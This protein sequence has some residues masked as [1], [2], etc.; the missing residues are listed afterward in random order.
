MQNAN[1]RQVTQASRKAPKLIS[2]A[3]SLHFL[4]A[5]RLQNPF[6]VIVGSWIE[7][8]MSLRAIEVKLS[9]SLNSSTLR[10][11]FFV[12]ASEKGR[13]P[14]GS[15]SGRQRH[16]VYAHLN[17]GAAGQGKVNG[18]REGLRKGKGREADTYPCNCTLQV[19]EWRVETA[20][21]WHH[22]AEVLE[23]RWSQLQSFV[24]LISF[25]ALSVRRIFVRW[26]LP[27]FKTSSYHQRRVNMGELKQAQERMILLIYH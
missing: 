13:L 3:F 22:Q 6:S 18:Q 21:C 20:S 8:E 14:A 26:S 25:A 7:T 15:G 4:S 24:S 9:L 12:V 27:Q 2:D 23:M 19:W 16:P 5:V 1:L 17:C 11:L 10:Q